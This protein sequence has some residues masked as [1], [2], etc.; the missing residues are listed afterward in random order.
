MNQ[1]KE[2]EYQ[3]NMA[4]L[5]NK[6]PKCTT[7]LP[8]KLQPEILKQRALAGEVP[9]KNYGNIRWANLAA[10]AC[11]VALIAGMGLYSS[12]NSPSGADNMKRS[13]AVPA[14]M[15]S[16]PETTPAAFSLMSDASI[17]SR[18]KAEFVPKSW[19]ENKH[20]YN[21]SDEN[22]HSFGRDSNSFTILTYFTEE[23]VAAQI[24][25]LG[26]E[27]DVTYGDEEISVTEISTGK[28]LSFAA[29]T[30]ELLS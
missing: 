15:E 17:V 27:V 14:A 11:A 12:V 4:Y 1:K 26:G 13:L 28:Q 3:E 6:M 8:L 16:A 20:H 24:V 22:V 18:Y 23:N 10:M 29:S 19:Q 21:I 5:R 9:T 2:R 25:I 7:E 30:L